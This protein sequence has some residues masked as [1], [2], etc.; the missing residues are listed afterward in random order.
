MH[1][2]SLLVV[3]AS[4][5]S[6]LSLSIP[7]GLS[8]R[9]LSHRRQLPPRIPTGNIQ[10]IDAA[11]VGNFD[12]T[13]TLTNAGNVDQACVCFK[14]INAN[15][16]LGFFQGNEEFEFVL[17]AN[18]GAAAIAADADSLGGCTC[19]AGSVPLTPFGAFASTFFEF[20]FANLERAGW[21][22]AV[23]SATVAGA[24]G[25]DFPGINVCAIGMCSTI[26]SD[27]TGSNAYLPGYE[28]EDRLGLNI[29]PR[30]INFD[31]TIAYAG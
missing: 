7:N 22:D 15:G 8:D 23:A 11:D 19:G 5:V 18:G 3:A 2:L 12:Y 1:A 13:A 25:F 24:A 26:N 29:A 6:A 28:S 20:R 4:A 14:T 31:V 27:G 17:T 21:S 16:Q 10:I 9:A 30:P